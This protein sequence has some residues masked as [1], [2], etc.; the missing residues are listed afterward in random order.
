[1]GLGLRLRE[2]VL[3]REARRM[4]SGW[5]R[6]VGATRTG[7]V[8]GDGVCWRSRRR[9]LRWRMVQRRR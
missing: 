7:G 1:M 6:V 2:L 5:I 8:G 4:V 3:R 9:N